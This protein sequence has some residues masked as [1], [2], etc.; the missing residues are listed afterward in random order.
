MIFQHV[1][2]NIYSA[3]FAIG[4]IENRL[5]IVGGGK[6][7][8]KRTNFVMKNKTNE[9]QTSDFAYFLST[10][11]TEKIVFNILGK[12]PSNGPIPTITKTIGAFAESRPGKVA[13]IPQ[14]TK[15]AFNLRCKM[16]VFKT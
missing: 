8:D 13:K 16:E 2:G 10:E 3:Q 12:N 7:R 5:I 15:G 6:P 9:L 4:N 11:N 1:L 14:A